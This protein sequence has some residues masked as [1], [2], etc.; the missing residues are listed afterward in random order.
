VIERLRERERKGMKRERERM[1]EVERGN[2]TYKFLT[3]GDVC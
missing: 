2:D 3:N 1:C